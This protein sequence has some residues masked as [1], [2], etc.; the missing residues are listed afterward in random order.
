MVEDLRNFREAYSNL[1]SWLAGKERM[2]SV[3]GPVATE[4]SML[5]NQQQ[6]VQVSSIQTQHVPIKVL[7]VKPLVDIF[8][9]YSPLF[10]SLT[11]T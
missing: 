2:V 1:S 10:P 5:D 7:F 3:L 9:L 8:L 4:P 6:Q 11:G